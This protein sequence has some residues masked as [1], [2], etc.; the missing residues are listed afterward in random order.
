MDQGEKTKP[1]G[2]DETTYRWR[3]IQTMNVDMFTVFVGR[4]VGFDAKDGSSSVNSIMPGQL[5]FFMR[6]TLLAARR[7]YG[8]RSGRPL[9]A[10]AYRG[11][12]QSR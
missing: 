5:A 4:L 7:L 2:T 1:P 10:P 12:G 8:R 9:S 3:H 6:R 11:G